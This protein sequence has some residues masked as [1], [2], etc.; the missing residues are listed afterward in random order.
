ML[1]LL[2]TADSTPIHAAAARNG[3]GKASVELLPF[4]ARKGFQ[5]DCGLRIQGG[6]NRRPEESPKHSFRLAF[7]KKYGAGNLDYPLFAGLGVGL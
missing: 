3:S 2:R 4:G 5:I 1:F 6:W 7:R